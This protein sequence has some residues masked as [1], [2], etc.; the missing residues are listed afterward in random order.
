M[1]HYINA[2]AICILAFCF[3]S[4]RLARAG[5]TMPM[6]FLTVGVAIGVTGLDLEPGAATTF[7]TLA[8]LTLALLLFADATLL[9]REAMRAIGNWTARMLLIGLP[10]AIA[11]GSLANWILLPDWPLWE[12]CLLAALLAPTDAAL[13]QSI[14]S[15]N[16]IPQ[17]LRDTLNAES[18]LNDGLALPFVI[19]FASLAAGGHDEP[20]TRLITSVVVQIGL[21]GLIGLAGG[22]IAGKLRGAAETRQ[23]MDHAL[24]GVATLALVGTVFFSAEH[25]G[26]NSFVAVFAAG[27]AYG[28]TA[29]APAGH[30]REFI[31]SD[32]QFL[33]IMSFFFIGAIFVP[34]ALSI[35]D[36]RLLTVFAVSLLVVRPVAIW[37]SLAG[38]D[39]TPN[40]RVFFGW[41]GPRGLA[42][43]L[44]AVFVIVDFGQLQNGQEILVA[45]IASVLV[46]AFAHGITARWAPEIFKLGDVAASTRV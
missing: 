27:F 34:A 44:F 17:K 46:S 21:G 7:H 43:A 2:I 28:V 25:L 6:V 12:I 33:A 8:E 20:E 23:L 14:K 1:D 36:I 9:N 40:E 13:G 5:V 16:A 37:V 38:T 10:L 24:E 35:L 45:A 3:F 26:G 19:F 22:W 31:E 18:G 11:F 39:A 15:N 41:F 42:T 29:G 4:A 32:G 30:A